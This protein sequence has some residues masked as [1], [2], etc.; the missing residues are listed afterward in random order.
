MDLRYIFKVGPDKG[1]GLKGKNYEGQPTEWEGFLT[2]ESPK[3]SRTLLTQCGFRSERGRAVGTVQRPDASTPL[4]LYP[5]AS[6]FA[7]ALS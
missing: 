1:W 4:V 3:A 6:G 7:R 2:V 5:A